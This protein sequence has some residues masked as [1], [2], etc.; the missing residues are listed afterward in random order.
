[1]TEEKEFVRQTGKVILSG[2]KHS[3]DSSN[4]MLRIL[5]AEQYLNNKVSLEIHRKFGIAVRFHL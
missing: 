2:F 3:G 4:L 1:M 5:E